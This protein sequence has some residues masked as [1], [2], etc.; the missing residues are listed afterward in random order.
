MKFFPICLVAIV[1][2]E[3]RV[4]ADVILARPIEM[5]PKLRKTISR[6]LAI[7][8]RRTFAR[9]RNCRAFILRLKRRFSIAA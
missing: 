9:Q 7:G 1:E 4:M 6:N 3:E 2:I 5:R 8:R